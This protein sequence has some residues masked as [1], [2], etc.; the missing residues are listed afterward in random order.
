MSSLGYSEIE[1][2]DNLVENKC[3][4]CNG[5]PLWREKPLPLILDRVD[6]NYSNNN[7]NCSSVWV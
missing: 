3:R 5:T 2:S 6:N 1:T 7:C 4:N